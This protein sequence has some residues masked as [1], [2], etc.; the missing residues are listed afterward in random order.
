MSGLSNETNSTFILTSPRR[1]GYSAILSVI[2]VL[3]ICFNSLLIYCFLTNRNQAWVKKSKRLFY[4]ILSDLLVG[5]ILVPR[6]FIHKVFPNQSESTYGICAVLS[7][8][9][10]STQSISYYQVLVL[11]VHRFITIRKIHLP[12]QVDTYRYGV[13]SLLIW[14]TVNVLCVP[15]YIFWG[16]HGDALTTCQ[17][18]HLFGQSDKGAV[19]YILTLFCVP[20]ILTNVIYVA[21]ACSMRMTTQ[22][23]HPGT[24]T[25]GES[26][27]LTNQNTANQQDVP[28][29]DTLEQP[30]GQQAIFTHVEVRNRRVIKA[31][32]L[33]L[34]VFNIS[35]LS[36]ILVPSMILQGKADF[37]PAEI[38]ALCFLNNICNPVIYMF[39]FSHLRD[40]VKRLLRRGLSR[41][42]NI[43]LCKNDNWD[44]REVEISNV[45]MYRTWRAIDNLRRIQQCERSWRSRCT[46]TVR[47]YTQC[48]GRG[49]SIGCASAWYAD[50]RGFDPHVRQHSFV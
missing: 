27:N 22:R 36:L 25:Q 44:K 26:F 2:C 28:A 23:V 19:V 42:Q 9:V 11:C 34:I 33:L 12:G 24:T 17:L 35:I 8:V 16:R 31:I 6:Q 14:V 50:G 4:L 43:L 21:I 3:S 47:F 10:I 37:L 41:L 32:G 48:A 40:E 29:S 5:V 7:F 49:S 15:P 38:Q 46:G 1:P 20:W 13:E 45:Y 18:S 30:S 39:S